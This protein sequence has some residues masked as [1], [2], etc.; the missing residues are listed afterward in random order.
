MESKLKKVNKI[1]KK[2]GIKEQILISTRKNNKFMLVRNGK[3]IHFGHPDYED[4]LDHKDKHRRK[5]YLSRAKGIRD[6]N[7]KL[8]Y[9]DKNSS[10]YY[11]IN[12]LW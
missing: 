6:G 8:T 10:N 2:M 7:G 1:A 9:K 3:S 12:L 4:F 11:S 5:R